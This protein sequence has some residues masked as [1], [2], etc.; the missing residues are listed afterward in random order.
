MRR[1]YIIGILLF[2]TTVLL[3]GYYIWFP[4]DYIFH[5]GID[6]MAAWKILEGQI[7]YKDFF[8]AQT[9]LWAYSIA[10][11]YALFGV[12]H[13]SGRIMVALWSSVLVV[14][15]YL[16]GIKKA[17]MKTGL[18]GALI[19]VLHP[20]AIK[21]GVHMLNDFPA[22]TLALIGN[23]YL[24][25]EYQKS[26][27]QVNSQIERVKTYWSANK[28]NLLAGICLGIGTSIKLTVAPLLLG[29]MLIFLIE[30]HINGTDLKDRIISI[31][32]LFLGFVISLGA[33][34]AY[35]LIFTREAFI[36]QILGNH[37][38]DAPIPWLYRFTRPLDRLWD[39]DKLLLLILLPSIPF[40]LKTKYGRGLIINFATLV[41]WMIFVVPY[42]HLNYYD[43]TL[44]IIAMICGFF[45]LSTSE[46]PNF[47]EKIHWNRA[48]VLKVLGLIL[49]IIYIIYLIFLCPTHVRPYY[50][51]D[52]G[53]K[54]VEW[55]KANTN[56]DEYILTDITNI[57]IEALRRGPFAEI[58]IDRMYLGDLTSEML[59]QSLYDYDIRVVVVTKRQFG[60]YEEYDEFMEFLEANY[61]ELEVG[62]WIYVRDTPLSENIR[63]TSSV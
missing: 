7:L 20:L 51:R 22:L 54:T 41:V 62:Y 31:L 21:Y 57:N 56:P 27:S 35:F 10:V 33:V 48:G 9:P 49:I 34:S 61:T 53:I 40:A 36:Y 60:R 13:T 19:I 26:D 24:F 44:P 45:P 29:F 11:V 52:Q 28:K 12:G 30:G 18:L 6:A 32:F 42:P 5:E 37:L 1:G 15:I 58:S 59:I 46:L 39:V 17:N 55:L 4:V 23:Y 25:T 38:A 2:I 8:N 16:S 14:F 50:E 3:R 43:M 63:L 47:R